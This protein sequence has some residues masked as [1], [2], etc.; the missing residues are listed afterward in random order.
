MGVAM[1]NNIFMYLQVAALDRKKGGFS[2]L[3]CSKFVEPTAPRHLS[4]SQMNEYTT[5]MLNIAEGRSIRAT[6]TENSRIVNVG[7]TLD[8]DHQCQ[9]ALEPMK[10]VQMNAAFRFKAVF[11]FTSSISNEYWLSIGQ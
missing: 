10:S 6:G 8:C 1:G 7:G 5:L 9:Q 3:F 11:L 2:R 4:W